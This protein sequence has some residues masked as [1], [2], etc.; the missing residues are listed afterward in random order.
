MESKQSV[1]RLSCTE[2]ALKSVECALAVCKHTRCVEE[3]TR[4]EYLFISNSSVSSG[5]ARGPYL[6]VAQ[7]AVLSRTRGG[8]FNRGL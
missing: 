6:W 3:E 2:G 1:V 8:T 5:Y 7:W 4:K